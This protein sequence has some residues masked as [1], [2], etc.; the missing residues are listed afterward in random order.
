MIMTAAALLSANPA[1]AEQEVREA[2]EGNLC[3][4]GSQRRI[5]MAVLKAAARRQS[6]AA[7]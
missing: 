6:G 3:R 1:P 7:R 5:V 4:C 2:L